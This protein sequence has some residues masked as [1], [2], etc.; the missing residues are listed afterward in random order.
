MLTGRVIW[1]IERNEYA[2][3]DRRLEADEAADAIRAAA[4]LPGS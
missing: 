4:A 3:P 1:A 2:R